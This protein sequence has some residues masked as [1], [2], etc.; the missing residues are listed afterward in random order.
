MA[1]DSKAHIGWRMMRLRND[2][3]DLTNEAL[4]LLLKIVL[5]GLVCALRLVGA[6]RFSVR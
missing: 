1:V 6:L 2:E 5:L 3:G 4:A